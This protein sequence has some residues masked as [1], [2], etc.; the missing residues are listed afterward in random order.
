MALRVICDV[1]QQASDGRGQLFLP[2][3]PRLFQMGMRES[4]NALR[5]ID[6]GRAQFRKQFIARCTRIEFR[7]Q[8]RQLLFSQTSSLGIRQEAIQ[9][10]SNVSQ[11]KR[12]GRHS[13]WSG[14]DLGIR[15]TAAPMPQVFL[16]QLQRMQDRAANGRDIKLCA[17]K[18]WLCAW[19][20]HLRST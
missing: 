2:H 11:V 6:E 15:Q 10:A 4:A 1:D 8:K 5:C 3:A 9:A 12:D 18:P 19:D 7:P 13:R 20:H 14:V 17:A 16:S